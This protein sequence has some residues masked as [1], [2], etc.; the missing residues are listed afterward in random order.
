MTNKATYE[1]FRSRFEMIEIERIEEM[2]RIIHEKK[3]DAFYVLTHGG[4]SDNRHAMNQP[5]W[6]NCVTITHCV[7]EST[8]PQGDHYICISDHMNKKYNTHY[9]VIPHIIENSNTKDHLRKELGLG[10]S[11]V[12]GRYG[13]YDDFNIPI[14]QEAI[15]IY[16]STNPDAYFLFMNTKPFYT[17]PR[18]IY[19][20][21]T[22]DP[23]YKDKFV[24]T[25]D[26]MIHARHMGETFGMAIAEFS[27]KNKPIITCRSNMDNAHLDILGK[28]AVQYDS[29]ESLLEIFENIREIIPLNDWTAYNQFSPEKIMALFDTLFRTKKRV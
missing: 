8:N 3:I 25:C 28:K 19:L 9:Q 18:I 12:F 20:D 15:R 4:P 21:M 27:I 17:H 5:I 29:L 23:V 7:F 22:T 16:L 13:G 11:M 6:G 10:D 2:E 24:N 14:A 1:K 26:A